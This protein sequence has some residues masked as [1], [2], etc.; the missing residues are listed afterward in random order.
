MKNIEILVEN[1]IARLSDPEAVI[2]CGNSDY[3]IKFLLDAEWEGKTA[4]T[5]RFVFKNDKGGLSY[6]EKAFV[7]DTVEVPILTDITFVYVGLYSGDLV[8]TTPATI[9]CKR[10]IL[11][12]TSEHEEPSEDV[13][14]QILE[15]I[16]AGVIKGEKGDKGEKGEKG[17]KGDAG[18]IKFIPVTSLPTEN[19]DGSAIYL[20]PIEGEE[21]DNRFTEYVYI[22]GNWEKLGEISV[23]VDHSEYVKFTDYATASKGGVAKVFAGNHGLNMTNG[24]LI[25]R[26]ANQTEIT[27]KTDPYKPITPATLDYSVKVGITTNTETWTDEEKAAACETIGA[28]KAQNPEFDDGATRGYVYFIDPNGNQ[29]VKKVQIQANYDTIPLR[30]PNGNFYVATPT[31]PYECTN[32]GYVDGL[33]AELLAR[34]EALEAKE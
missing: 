32:K 1:K 24:I 22:D 2:V 26:P 30:N 28:V 16:N 4:K 33:I 8:T 5:A 29:I 6:K 27:A 7:G 12:G 3:T 20:L 18:V 10:S 31:L 19:I 15:L 14:N 21:A 11:C 23:Q 13:Y 25:I 34:I 9:K 17:D